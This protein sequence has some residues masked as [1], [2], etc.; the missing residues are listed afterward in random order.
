M[1]GVNA[2]VTW[3]GSSVERLDNE[4]ETTKALT[5]HYNLH[6]CMIKANALSHCNQNI[7]Y[8]IASL[9]LI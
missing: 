5:V 8:S 6:Y 2:L 9:F 7:L 4:A 3:L 1:I